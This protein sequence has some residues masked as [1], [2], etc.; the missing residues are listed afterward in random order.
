M[1][2]I[3]NKVLLNNTG[4]YIQNLVRNYNGK[5]YEKEYVYIVFHIMYVYKHV[6]VHQELMQHCKSTMLQFK[7][8]AW[9][10]TC[11]GP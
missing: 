7:K 1:Y 5:E 6:S 2:K 3:E 10:V 9:L 4:N 8:K 11:C